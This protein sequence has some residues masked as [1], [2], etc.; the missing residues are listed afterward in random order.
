[1]GV[2]RSTLRAFALATQMGFSIAVP[3]VAGVA[4]GLFLDDRLGT[5]PIFLI[6]GILLGLVLATFTLYK[7]VS[8]R[9]SRDSRNGT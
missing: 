8:F 1:M 7:L 6:V 5:K 2:D 3:L 4:G 9:T